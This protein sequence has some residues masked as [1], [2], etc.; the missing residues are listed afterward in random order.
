MV[1]LSRLVDGVQSLFGSW[2][3]EV[4]EATGVIQRQRK[5]SATTLAVTFILGFLRNPR[6]SD[7]ELAQMAAVVGEAVT[8]QAIEQRYHERMIDF[9]QGLFVKAA[10]TQIASDRVLAPLLER[11]SDVQLLDST[12]ISL[13]TDIAERFA[14]RFVGCGGNQGGTAAL[15]LQVRLSLK[16]GCLDAVRVEAG[17]DCDVKTPLQNDTPKPGSLR[18]ADLGY[19]DTETF[20]RIDQA[21]AYWLSPLKTGIHVRDL[22]GEQSGEQS[23]ECFE[24]IDWLRRNDAKLGTVIDRQVQ[25]TDARMPCRLI[26]WRLPQEV[27]DRRRRRLLEQSRRKG[28]TPSAER[29]AQCDWAILI[30]NLPAE[31]LSVDEARVLY[32]ARWQI[33][34][35][36]K[37]WKSQGFVDAMT[38][39]CWIRCLVKLWSRLLAAIVQQWLQ[40]S[41]WGRPEI[42][43]KKVWDLLTRLA[44]SLATAW[45]D[46]SKLRTFLEDAQRIAQSTV[47]QNK[48]KKPST[49]EML[50]DPARLPYALT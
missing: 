38:D 21:G 3:E 26:A 47:R 7:E 42:S 30:T 14:E 39:T 22:S 50:N 5:F 23:G 16:T 48:R 36:F 15:K 4:A 2:C 19:F 33:E 44:W 25:I 6:S 12:T 34:L 43:L 32:R 18:I 40:S 49:F 45:S 9:L 1:N 13:P 31:R 8:P 29:L 27:A 28:R 20:R 46:P 11:F 10:Q 41:V 35:L 17:R 24:L 37:R